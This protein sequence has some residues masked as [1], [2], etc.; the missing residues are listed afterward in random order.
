LEVILF[1][2]VLPPKMA[3]M[4]LKQLQEQHDKEID[5]LMKRVDELNAEAERLIIAGNSSANLEDRKNTA[6]AAGE[7]LDKSQHLLDI[8]RRKISG[9]QL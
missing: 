9:E 7:R 4:T 2:N 6:S 8:I 5:R 3:L 1:A